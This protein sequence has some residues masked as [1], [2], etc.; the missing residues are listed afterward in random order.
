MLIFDV[1]LFLGI[2]AII[3][4]GMFVILVWI[5][6]PVADRSRAIPR[7]TARQLRRAHAQ[8]TAA[9]LRRRMGMMVPA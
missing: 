8:A 9:D 3:T 4:L 2:L 6:V 5:L 1:L 7:V